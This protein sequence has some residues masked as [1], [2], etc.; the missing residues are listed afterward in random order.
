MKQV[1]IYTDGACLG[2]PGPGGWGALLQY[3]GREKEL[4]GS[5]PHTTNN[6]MELMGAIAALQ[7]LK[8]P[9]SI[10]LHTDST[11]VMKGMSEWIKGW[12][13][14]GWKTADKKPV[15]NADLWQLLLDAASQHKV[16]WKWVKA[17]NGHPENERVDVLARD[18]ALKV[19]GR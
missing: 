14:K 3:E 7:Q 13:A 1:V 10:T 19:A 5:E 17:H 11:Y 12:V 18:A 4:S 9:C 6:R 16:Q 8:E 2:N 15:K